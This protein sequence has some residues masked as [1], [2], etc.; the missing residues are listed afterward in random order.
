MKIFPLVTNVTWTEKVLNLSEH[1]GFR[2]RQ[3]HYNAYVEDFTVLQMAHGD[4]V[5]QFEE[6]PTKTCKA[7][8]QI[9]SC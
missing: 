5:V 7:Y 8:C 1:M 6:T 4:K 3:D 9:K 2:G